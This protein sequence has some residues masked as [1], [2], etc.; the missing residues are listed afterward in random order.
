MSESKSTSYAGGGQQVVDLGARRALQDT[1]VGAGSGGGDME[2]RV[3]ALEGAVGEIRKDVTEIKVK[4]GRIEGE[5]SRLPGYPGIFMI[6]G[7]IVAI[8]TAVI[9]F[10]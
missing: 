10:T 9:K 8:G 4:L 3:T 6:V 2:R 7:T 5:I 1:V